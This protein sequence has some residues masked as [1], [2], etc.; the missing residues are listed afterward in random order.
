MNHC[1]KHIKKSELAS[2]NA[3][4][5]F[6]KKILIIED[7]QEYREGL[8]EA[9]ADLGHVI[10]CPEN[11]TAMPPR[12]EIIK[13]IQDSDI[14]LLDDDF[15]FCRFKG[16]D[17]FPFC[18]GKSVIGI[19]AAYKFGEKN[20]TAKE[21]FSPSFLCIHDRVRKERLLATV[22]EQKDRLRNLIK[23]VL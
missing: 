13:M 1:N 7:M 23:E 11:G 10:V 8:Q 19:S 2:Q 18:K 6:M 21:C 4:G 17:L 20:F 5:N 9:I 12:E 16:R 3:K 14:I 22:R 15:G